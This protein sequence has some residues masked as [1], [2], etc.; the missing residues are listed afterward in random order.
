M[1]MALWFINHETIATVGTFRKQILRK[2]E[3]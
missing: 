2:F 1:S 3:Q